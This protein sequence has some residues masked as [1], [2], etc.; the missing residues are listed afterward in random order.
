LYQ[1]LTA[2]DQC[3]RETVCVRSAT[4][5]THA[6]CLIRERHVG[7]LVMA[8]E[9]TTGRVL[10]GAISNRD[11][12]TAVLAHDDLIAVACEQIQ[13]VARALWPAPADARSVAGP[14]PCLPYP[15]RGQLHPWK[16]R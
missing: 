3:S 6:A 7:S 12:V 13:A 2:G 14:D 10:A 11:A 1:R 4:S 9:R 8:D 15:E 16:R 5:L